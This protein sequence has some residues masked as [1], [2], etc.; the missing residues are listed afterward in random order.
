M[1]PDIRVSRTTHAEVRDL[2]DELDEDWRDLYREMIQLGLK[3][4][5]RR[6]GGDVSV[7]DVRSVVETLSPTDS[8]HV[9]AV[10]ADA[11][12]A[13]WQLLQERGE[14]SP[15]EIKRALY[16]EHACGHSE[17]WWW[18][19]LGPLIDELPGV[20]RANQRRFVATADS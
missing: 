6:A 18:K 17:E 7:S 3:E 12:V 8:D 14:A 2:A 20:E 15:S 19:K 1:R 10:E 11:L 4:K 13:I 5:R 9:T 16:D